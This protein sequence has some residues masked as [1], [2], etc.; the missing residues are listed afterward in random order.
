MIGEWVGFQSTV[1]APFWSEMYG[2]KHLGAIKSLGAAAMVFFT[3]V[4]PIVIGW[5]IDIVTGMDT[6]A[7]AAAIYIFLT[8]GL[9]YYA[10]RS[11][12]NTLRYQQ[13]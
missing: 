6:L 12:A 5:Q 2:N 1:T 10:C 13:L 8:S 11:R 3:A 4:S 9:A 7:I